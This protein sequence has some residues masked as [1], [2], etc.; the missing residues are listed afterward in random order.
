MSPICFHK[1]LGRL[2]GRMALNVY[3][4]RRKVKLCKGPLKMLTKKLCPGLNFCV[5]HPPFIF[6]SGFCGCTIILDDDAPISV[7]LD[8][9]KPDGSIPALMG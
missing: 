2:F 1:S 9:T 7:T 6:L 4:L 3:L 8:D 5:D